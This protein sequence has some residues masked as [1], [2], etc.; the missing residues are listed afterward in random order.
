MVLL[1]VHPRVH[2]DNYIYIHWHILK[3]HQRGA[4]YVKENL[5]K[6][7]CRIGARLGMSYGPIICHLCE[8]QRDKHNFGIA[9]IDRNVFIMSHVFALCLVCV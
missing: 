6:A 9:N 2:S 1:L 7:I 3:G 5:H 4:E 8:E